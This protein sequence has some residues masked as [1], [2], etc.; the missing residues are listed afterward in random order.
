M[1]W[2]FHMLCPEQTP[3]C[4]MS[5]SVLSWGQAYLIRLVLSETSTSLE[6]EIAAQFWGLLAGELEQVC[7]L[8]WTV[9]LYGLGTLLLILS[10]S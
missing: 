2:L 4:F 1:I 5:G 6:L 3:P 9:T 8:G 7:G 10:D